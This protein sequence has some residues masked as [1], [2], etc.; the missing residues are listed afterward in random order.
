MS[1]KSRRPVGGRSVG[2]RKVWT[3]PALAAARAF[4]GIKPARALRTGGGVRR[5]PSEV[6]RPVAAYYLG[7][8]G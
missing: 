1:S 3:A 4:L 2:G 6:S 8:A 7:Q 5:R